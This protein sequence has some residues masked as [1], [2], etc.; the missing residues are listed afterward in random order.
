MALKVLL[1]VVTGCPGHR[2]AHASASPAG[3]NYH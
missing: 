1:L 2:L 3:A